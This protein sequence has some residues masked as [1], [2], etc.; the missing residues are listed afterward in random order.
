MTD[1]PIPTPPGSGVLVDAATL[2]CPTCGIARGQIDGHY[3]CERDSLDLC[4]LPAEPPG[5]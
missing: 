4:H 5:Q 2:T 1:Q 3:Y